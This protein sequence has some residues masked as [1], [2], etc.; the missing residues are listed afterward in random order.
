MMDKLKPIRFYDITDYVPN[1][2]DSVILQRV[3]DPKPQIADKAAAMQRM[4]QISSNAWIQNP[5]AQM[6]TI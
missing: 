1:F 5:D 3:L 6:S 4:D 2:N